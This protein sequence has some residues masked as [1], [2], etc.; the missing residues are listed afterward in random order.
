MAFFRSK[1]ILRNRFDVLAVFIIECLV[2]SALPY[3]SGRVWGEDGLIPIATPAASFPEQTT[4]PSPKASRKME[5]NE[6]TSDYILGAEDVLE[7]LVWR[8]ESL[9]RTVTIR[10]DG[11]ISLPLIGEI[12]AAG[13][14]PTQLRDTIKERLKEYKE[15]PEV[16]IIVRE[17]NSFSIFITG[18]IAHPGKLQLRSFTTFLQGIILSGGFTQNADTNRILLLRREGNREVRMNINYADI[19]NGT[20]PNSNLILQRGDTIVVPTIGG[21]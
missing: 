7:V 21:R 11:K 2:I 14:A 16:S 13:L 12:Q 1:E 20:N 9:S 3:G 8:N 4:A 10:P 19:V 17:I 5:V 6:P 18:E 15:T